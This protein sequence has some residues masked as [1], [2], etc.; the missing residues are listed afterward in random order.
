MGWKII[1]RHR[2]FQKGVNLFRTESRDK[3]GTA[4]T[5][6]A[7]ERADSFHGLIASFYS[8][9]TKFLLEDWRYVIGRGAVRVFTRVDIF[10]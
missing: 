8:I 9:K 2:A 10:A 4:S 1:S 5:A 7:R 3:V 6:G